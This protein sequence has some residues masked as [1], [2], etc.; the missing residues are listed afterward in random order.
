MRPL[1]IV[2]SYLT[3]APD[4]ALL[5]KCLRSIQHT[6]A[7]A[8]D[9]LV[10]DDG[11]PSQELVD[12]LERLRGDLGFELYRKPESSGFAKAANVGL[13]R[14]LDE[15]RDAVLVNAGVELIDPGWLEA[16]VAQRTLD[17]QGRA[18]V[19]GGLLLYPDGRIQHAGMYLSTVGS[20][21]GRPWF[22]HLW[23]HAPGDLPEARLSRVCPVTGALLFVRHECVRSVGIFDESF[24]MGAEDVDYCIRVLLEG[25]E[26]VYQ[27]GVRAYH[28][29]GVL[30]DRSAPKR[31]VGSER[32]MERLWEKYGGELL[33]ELVPSGSHLDGSL[34]VDQVHRLRRILDSRKRRA[35]K[36]IEKLERKNDKLEGKLEGLKAREKGRAPSPDRPVRFVT[37][38]S[39][40]PVDGA[41]WR[42]SSAA[43]PTTSYGPTSRALTGWHWIGWSRV[44]LGPGPRSCAW[45]TCPCSVSLVRSPRT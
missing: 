24:S 14:C 31:S 21:P 3:D 8:A 41:A 1:I 9:V 29:D 19:V 40:P 22:D 13:R 36:R 11:S 18:S 23:R 44:W 6:E 27:P 5:E 37:S 7:E 43:T 35:D 4:A 42:P 2:P 28:D 26:C 38:F 10:V 17:G 45:T 20:R 30:D 32:S 34:A 33:E 25:R 15:G 39:T 12:H 16:M